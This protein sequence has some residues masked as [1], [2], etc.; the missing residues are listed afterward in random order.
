[1]KI[2]ENR[3]LLSE[4]L[5]TEMDISPT[6]KDIIDFLCARLPVGARPEKI[7]EEKLRVYF[8]AHDK[9]INQNVYV[10]TVS[11]YGVLALTNDPVNEDNND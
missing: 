4:S 2:R 6:K 7:A 10:V 5:Q 3:G 8:Y 11:G 9:R 1:M